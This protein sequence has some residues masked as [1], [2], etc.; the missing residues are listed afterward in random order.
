M[1]EQLLEQYEK[2]K[3]SVRFRGDLPKR[4]SAP[5]CLYAPERWKNSENRV[6]IIGQETLGW[7]FCSGRYYDWPYEPIAN[8]QDFTRVQDSVTA[9]VH[10]YKSF[11]FS[12][13]Q[14]E[15]YRSPFW[16]AY[17][18]FR[19][20][21]G[22]Q[23]DG[24]ETSVLWTNLFRMSLDGGSVIKGS[25]EEVEQI[26]EASRAVLRAELRI[27]KPTAV[28]FFTGPKYNEALYSLFPNIE[29]FSFNGR[30]PQKTAQ[31]MHPDLPSMAWRTY[32]PKYLSLS[33]QWG[34]IDEILGKLCVAHNHQMQPT[35]YASSCI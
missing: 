27:L 13:Y 31:I 34:V 6:L 26:R 20:V 24:V 17:R 1:Q 10:G 19:E 16:Q 21:L 23:R 30:D 22:E 7:G 3:S 2:L 15:N 32:H 12:R 18:Q 8:W 33:Q 5:L 29:V 28:V 4:L 9:M 14:P 35:G 11:E 25:R